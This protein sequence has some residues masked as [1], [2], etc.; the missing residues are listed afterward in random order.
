MIRSLVIPLAFALLA[1]GC[2]GATSEELK[3]PGGLGVIDYIPVPDPAGP[4]PVADPESVVAVLVRFVVGVE[5]FHVYVTDT[6]AI[7]QLIDIHDGR[8]TFTHFSGLIRPGSGAGQENE[9]WNW[10]LDGRSVI[11]NTLHDPLTSVRGTPQFIDDNHESLVFQNL[12]YQITS[13][14]ALMADLVPY[15]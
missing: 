8:E 7:K 11:V 14:D 10:Y 12:H 6:R 3:D 1:A 9:P 2:G 15:R 5:S 4:G 13:A